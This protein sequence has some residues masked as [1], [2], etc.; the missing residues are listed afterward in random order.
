M[1][2]TVVWTEF[3]KTQL[4]K[5]FD[6]YLSVAGIKVARQIVD[7]IIR[8]TDLL[9]SNPRIGQC[10]ELLKQYLE[11]F[12]YLVEGNYKIIY[13]FD[14]NQVFISSVFDCRR[15]PIRMEEFKQ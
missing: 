6:Y 15:N 5:I 8:R 7:R 10:E 13:W 11:K 14:D 4:R 3:S 9:T 1:A 2:L 12:R